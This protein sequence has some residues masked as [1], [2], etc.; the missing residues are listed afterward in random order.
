MEMFA[1]LKI[2]WPGAK[3]PLDFPSTSNFSHQTP[4]QLSI[5]SMGTLPETIVPLGGLEI[6]MQDVGV[7]VGVE[8]GVGVGVA[9]GVEVGVGVALFCT[10]SDS[11]AVPSTTLPGF[12][13][14][15][16]TTTR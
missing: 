4:A 11:L 12:W 9:V 5:V 1:L 6:V 10:F 16:L 15:L 3:P 7:A 13:L 8:V 14:W 2:I